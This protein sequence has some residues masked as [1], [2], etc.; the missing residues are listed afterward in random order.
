M[1]PDSEHHEQTRTG[2]GPTVASLVEARFLSILLVIALV[3][4]FAIRALTD[5][6]PDRGVMIVFISFI[7]SIPFGFLTGSVAKDLFGSTDW[8]FLVD[9]DAQV[10]DGAVF[11]M[12]SADLAEFTVT[13]GQL[14]ELSPT[15]YVGKNVDLEEQ[16]V[17]GTWRGTLDD[18]ELARALQKVRECRGQLEEDAKIGFALETQLHSVVR[19]AV[20]SNVRTIVD[21]FE[22]GTLPENGAALDDA[23]TEAL[24]GFDIRDN[25]DIDDE[26]EQFVEDH[27]LEE[28]R[29]AEIEELQNGHDGDPANVPLE[30]SLRYGGS[31]DD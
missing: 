30:K 31:I 12:P 26:F 21:T 3:G 17:K 16:T 22:S 13:E 1:I 5:W 19:H 20:R 18:R 11:R 4:F 10:I 2:L 23:V 14:T 29:D 7:A 15:L 24:D 27:S 6:S 25:L 9:L 28:L 8:V